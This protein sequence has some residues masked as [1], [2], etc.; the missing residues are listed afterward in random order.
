MKC[1]YMRDIFLI[2]FIAPSITF[3]YVLLYVIFIQFDIMQ[4]L[5][6]IMESAQSLPTQM[7]LHWEATGG[8]SY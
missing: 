7:P 4:T 6:C 1:K 5:Y 3:T 2:Q 8:T